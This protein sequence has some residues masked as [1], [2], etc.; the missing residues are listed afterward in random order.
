MFESCLFFVDKFIDM[1]VKIIFCDLY[2][3]IVIGYNFKL[4]LKFIIMVFLDIR[5]GIFL[6]IVVFLVK[7]IS[8]IYNI[9]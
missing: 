7:G 1:G 2:R 5:V 6:L 4:V 8:I 3:V 9:E